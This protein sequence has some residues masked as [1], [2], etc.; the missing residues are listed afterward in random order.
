MISNPRGTVVTVDLP[1][2]TP[3]ARGSEPVVETQ[4]RTDT[5]P[6]AETETAGAGHG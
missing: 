2:T 6:F 1:V 3:P 5:A 4:P